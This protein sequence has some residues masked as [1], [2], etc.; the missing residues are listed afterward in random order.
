MST[1]ALEAEFDDVRRATSDYL[2]SKPFTSTIVD[3]WENK[4]GDSVKMVNRY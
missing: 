2:D 4:A 3:D 1:T